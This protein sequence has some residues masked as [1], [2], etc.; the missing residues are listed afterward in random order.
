ME[1]PAIDP[2]VINELHDGDEAR[3]AELFAQMKAD[4]D[5]LA[6]R[7][8]ARALVTREPARGHWFARAREAAKAN[9]D[10]SSIGQAREEAGAVLQWIDRGVAE[11]MPP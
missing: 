4:A 11:A 10:S 1:T 7:D 6:P 2:T 9:P 3:W 5:A 8:L